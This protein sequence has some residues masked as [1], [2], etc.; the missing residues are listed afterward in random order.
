MDLQK[1]NKI[2]K[3]VVSSAM[4]VNALAAPAAVF[5]ATDKP[6]QSAAEAA[7]KELIAKGIL[8]GD[9][10]GA[11]NLE[12]SLTRIQVAAILA[13]ALNL[14]AD[15][16]TASFSDVSSD[17]W[18]LKYIAALDK[19]G[20][21]SGADGKFRPNDVTTRE[22]LAAI[23]VRVTQTN[24][25]GKGNNLTISDANQVSDWAKAYVQAAIEQKLISVT[26]GKFEPQKKVDRQEVALVTDTFIKSSSFATYKTN[27]NTLFN[28]GKKISNSDPSV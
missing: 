8:T 12:G 7:A 22:E 24:I 10:T 11:L 13:R 19:L 26:N 9:E 4:V 21:M 3:Y 16:K 23:L 27:V 17:S 28:E 1:K 6:A 20:I 14:N 25:E 15:S 18:G 5:A 2:T